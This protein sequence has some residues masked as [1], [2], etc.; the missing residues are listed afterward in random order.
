MQSIPKARNKPML[1]IVSERKRCGMSQAELARRAG[2][3]QAS[4]SRIEAGKEPAYRDRGR[5][6]ARAIGWDGDPEALFTEAE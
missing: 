6:I 4:M 1:R 5:R 2:I 3:N